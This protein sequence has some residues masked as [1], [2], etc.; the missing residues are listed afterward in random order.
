MRIPAYRVLGP[1]VLLLTLLS[2]PVALQVGVSPDTEAALPDDDPY[3]RQAASAEAAFEAPTASVVAVYDERGCDVARLRVVAELTLE[4]ASLPGVE[5]VHSVANGSDIAP[6]SSELLQ[7][8][9]LPSLDQAG[10]EHLREAIS[11]SPFHRSL[12]FR[13]A[14]PPAAP[15]AGLAS[16]TSLAAPQLN[17]RTG[18]SA[19]PLGGATGGGYWLIHVVAETP[20]TNDAVYDALR[21]ATA[22]YPGVDVFGRAATDRVLVNTIRAETILAA[23]VALV[24]SV[25]MLLVLTRDLGGVVAVSLSSL[26]PAILCV[27][28]MQVLNV[29]ISIF[30]SFAPVVVFVFATSFGLHVYH[31]IRRDPSDETA[32]GVAG[33]VALAGATTVLGY[34]A[35][36]ATSLAFLR[37]VAIVIIGGV[38]LAYHVAFVVVPSILAL[39]RRVRRPRGG[40]RSPTRRSS[41]E[42]RVPSPPGGAAG[43]SSPPGEA[44]DVSGAPRAGAE[45]PRLTNASLAAGSPRGRITGASIGAAVVIAILVASALLIPRLGFGSVDAFAANRPIGRFLAAQIDAIGRGRDLTIYLEGAEPYA[46]V[47]TAVYGAVS[48]LHDRLVA[49]S[50]EAAVLS[51]VPAVRWMNGRLEGRASPVEP[52]GSEQIG[53]SYEL[54]RS[55]DDGQTLALYLDGDYRRTRITV[56]LPRTGEGIV[57]SAIVDDVMATIGPVEGL[58]ATIVGQIVAMERLTNYLRSEGVRSIG[59]FFCAAA[60]VL[61]AV[62]RSVSRALVT[63]LPS[64]AAAVVYLGWSGVFGVDV[65]GFT[66]IMIAALVG[67][68]NDDAV[69]LISSLRRDEAV[70]ATLA[71]VRPAIVHTTLTLS[72]PLL[73]LL[74]SSLVELRYAT[75]LLS[76]SWCFGTAFV[77]FLLPKL[78]TV[79]RVGAGRIRARRG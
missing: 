59:L 50:G 57:Y 63:L 7:T 58:T 17:P 38:L 49:N 27:A 62:F 29:E 47:D 37:T 45:Q 4:F 34:A 3:A 74:V 1:I 25:L 69:V 18:S 19:E 71:A 48:A 15:P 44:A 14:A 65:T 31:R 10:V 30:N 13:S 36:L 20:Q 68:T 55:L 35:T 79:L 32:R 46:L 52:N 41:I 75:L 67:V 77:I 28:A 60:V 22:D 39:W 51:V 72:I 12:F 6:S 61:L 8:E 66:P 23:A 40:P 43:E 54:L 53:E 21:A 70:G 26:S 42:R 16:T 76:A 56:G 78:L 5:A 33:P 11:R 2:L 9:L 24:L 64:A 73:S